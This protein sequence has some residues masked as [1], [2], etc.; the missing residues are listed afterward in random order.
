MTAYAEVN[1][2]D[3]Y[4][5]VNMKLEVETEIRKRAGGIGAGRERE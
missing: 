5:T 4:L 2:M 1:E 3:Y